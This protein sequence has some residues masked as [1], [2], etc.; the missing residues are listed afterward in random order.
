MYLLKIWKTKQLSSQFKVDFFWG[1]GGVLAISHIPNFRHQFYQKLKQVSLR[2]LK[3]DTF[4]QIS[5]YFD[6][7]G[8]FQESVIRLRY[9]N[10]ST[11][12]HDQ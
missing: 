3:F 4:V 8:S 6:L 1:G 11:F 5:T 7:F 2:L 10:V 12:L 9:D